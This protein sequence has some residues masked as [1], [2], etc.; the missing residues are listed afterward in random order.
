MQLLLIA[1]GMDS[2]AAF[3]QPIRRV[4]TRVRGFRGTEMAQETAE[5]VEIEETVETF[6]RLGAPGSQSTRF[7]RPDLGSRP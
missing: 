1:Q 2:K 7:G 3:L 6:K 5:T 4:R